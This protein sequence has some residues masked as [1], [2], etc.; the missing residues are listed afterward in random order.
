[1]QTLSKKESEV[2]L[3]RNGIPTD[4]GDKSLLSKV[5]SKVGNYVKNSIVDQFKGGLQTAKEGFSAAGNS[6]GN[7]LTFGENV[8]KGLS[9]AAGAVTAP[10]APIAKPVG[11]AVEAMAGNK[12]PVGL[13]N[14]PIVQKFSGTK[15]GA[16]T[17][18]VAEDVSNAANVA[19]TVGGFMGGPKVAGKAVGTTETAMQGVKGFA[20][21][22]AENVGEMGGKVGTA[23]QGLSKGM[24]PTKAQII[25]SEIAKAFDLTQGDVKN[26]Y[27]STG[28]DVGSFLSKNNLLAGGVDETVSLLDN[29]SKEN[30][31][32]VRQIISDVPKVYN[33]MDVPRYQEALGEILKQTADT[34]GLQE[35]TAEVGNLLKKK[36]IKLEDVQRVKELMDEHFN[37]YKV[38]GDVK[39]GIAKKG[40]TNIRKDIQTF[41][42]NQVKEYSGQDI[43]SL[44]KNVQTSKSIL[45]AI[46]TRATRGLTRANISLG[47]WG[48]FFG[49]TTVSGGNPFVGAAAV[50][51]KKLYQNP[52][53]KLKVIKYLENLDSATQAS[54]KSSLLSGNIPSQLSQFVKQKAAKVKEAYKNSSL[55]DEGG[56][57]D[58]L[59]KAKEA[60]LEDTFDRLQTRKVQLLEEG[61]SENSPAVRNLIKQLKNISDQIYETR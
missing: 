23:M 32:Q 46:E 4:T 43:R 1:M 36:N 16:A 40:L 21:K 42:E 13:A 52:N 31:N 10:F 26:I 22:T 9:G 11:Y 45:N 53:I 12:G 18:R 54:V 49:A 15:A 37:L 56:Y 55:S 27:L 8:L 41:I 58:F 25:N 51:A 7:P 17:A 59:G 57:V 2:V 28:N 20:A 14:L 24:I 48:A 47:D 39:E 60:Q 6:S 50:F 33:A 3:K 35:S 61:Y 29:F 30:Y 34:P 19:G 5:G 38:T 44:N